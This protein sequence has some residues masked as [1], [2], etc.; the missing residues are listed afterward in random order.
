[1]SNL[2]QDIKWRVLVIMLLLM[3]TGVVIW[4]KAFQ[5]YSVQGEALLQKMEDAYYSY[6][7][8]EAS[9]GN[10]YADDNSLLAT[11]LPY[12]EAYWDLSV[13]DRDTFY[14][15]LDR[16]SA[17]MSTHIN[18]DMTQGALREKYRLAQSKK[19]RYLLVAKDISYPQLL[20]MQTFP[21]FKKGKFKGGLIVKEQNKRLMPFRMLAART[22]GKYEV[23]DRPVVKGA[24]EIKKDTNAV[25]IEGNF[26]SYLAGEDRMM[27]MQ[28]LVDNTWIPV[29]D[30]SDLEPNTGKDV[31]TTLD[32]NI[33]DAA[34]N[35]LYKT[36][37][38]YN[39]RSGCAVVMEVKTGAIKAIANLG[40]MQSGDYWESYNFALAEATEPGSTFKAASMLAM[41]DDGM[42]TNL[43]DTVE[44]NYGKAKFY[45]AN[46]ED[47]NDH[48]LNK[49]SI[50]DLFKVSSNVGMAKL[51]D[52][53]YNRTGKKQQ[54]IDKLKSFR[55]DQQTGVQLSG[56]GMPFIKSANA[57][58]F[59]GISPLWMGIG[60]ELQITPLQLLAFYNAV[61]NDGRYMQ[62]FLVKEIREYG[63]TIKTFKPIVLERQIAS[64]EAIGMLK[65]LLV[66][67][68]KEG[69]AK[70]INSSLYQIAGKTGTA[71]TNFRKF[72]S[73]RESKKY[74]ASFVGFFPAENPVYSCIVVMQ[75]PETGIY[76]GTVA[77]P[78][79]R[80]IADRAYALRFDAQ[81]PLGQQLG[82]TPIKTEKL[83]AFTAGFYDEI[84]YLTRQTQL[85]F[86]RSTATGGWCS[87]WA[88]NDTLRLETRPVQK[89]IVPSVIGMGLRDAL[90]L[91]EQ[92]GL[93]VKVQGVGKVKSQSIRPGQSTKNNRH[94]YLLLN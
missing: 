89:G 33:Q 54:F 7:P 40:K 46:L 35:A 43:T 25:G 38:Q 68:V 64:T 20:K 65:E 27:L 34:E 39:A 94:I 85:P 1:M 71:I 72:T 30:I 32:V 80:E 44:L 12:Y 15:Y 52:R 28:R 58:D 59:S 18:R 3:V 77:A 63:K 49:A 61:A 19:D 51:I 22:I 31:V 74:Q 42:V 78:V 84:L 90:Y 92:Q 87:L 23:V 60:Y 57:A 41:L 86:Q 11:S 45:D 66:A 2:S 81:K 75:D 55:L 67:V 50:K 76:G 26:N 62:P 47:A 70:H 69:S 5:V 79:F 10:I 48:G 29:D 73:G 88:N 17:Q 6:R 21:I 8:V 4:F 9:R 37:K 91:L 83:P 13:V 14:V 93:K 82:K 36:L 24:N 56:E 53:N 16:L